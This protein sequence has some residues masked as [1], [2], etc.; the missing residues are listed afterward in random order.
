[1]ERITIPGILC[2]LALVFA[3]DATSAAT[4]IYRDRYVAPTKA[5]NP[6][7]TLINHD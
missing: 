1:M 4:T 3:I 6:R 2:C 7:S 5:A